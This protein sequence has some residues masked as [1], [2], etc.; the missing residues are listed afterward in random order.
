MTGQRPASTTLYIHPASNSPLALV[1]RRGPSKWWHFL[2]WDRDT[3]LITPGSWFNG[4]I[5]PGRCDLSPRGDWMVILAFM[6]A[7]D[8]CAWTALCHAPSAKASC[9]IPQT[10]ARHG[11]GFFDSRQPILWLNNAGETFKPEHHQK[12]PF[13]LGY[14]EKDQPLY[15]SLADR[16]ERDGWK[17]P[18]AG[19]KSPE[20]VAL[21]PWIKK[22]P[23]KDHELLLYAPLPVTT[24]AAEGEPV[25]D[26]A[27]FSYQVRSL[28]NPAA[29]IPI[30]NISWA[31]WNRRGE[32]CL[33]SGGILCVANPDTP[34]G[35]RRL[36]VDLNTLTP[37]QKR[38]PAPAAAPT[39][40]R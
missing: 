24:E 5:Y 22:S 33:A 8:P 25:D 30:E 13:E 3:G 12:H 34:N 21:L 19:K 18:G 14:Q 10:T 23:T 17:H 2:L 31:N 40:P 11:G 29:T 37:R 36:V 27:P 38:Q 20:Q 9:F 7:N 32:L 26:P 6:G 35:N 15:G 4:M 28:A 39:P 16:L 1:I